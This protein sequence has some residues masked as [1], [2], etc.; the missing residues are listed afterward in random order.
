MEF[1]NAV[2][3]AAAKTMSKYLDNWPK[4]RMV[5]LYKH[6]TGANGSLGFHIVGVDGVNMV[7]ISQVQ[8]DKPA[9]LSKQIF[10]GDK[11]L[12]VNGFD[13][14]HSNHEGAAKALKKA[15]DR[16]DLILVH[17][18]AEFTEF[19]SKFQ[20]QLQ[21]VGHGNSSLQPAQS[22]R[23]IQTENSSSKS[24]HPSESASC[25]HRYVRSQID[26]DPKLDP[27]FEALGQSMDSET[28]QL[29]VRFKAG[30]VFRV[31]GQLNSDWWI[32]SLPCF[33]VYC[34]SGQIN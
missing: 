7:F 4:A 32:V 24:R 23:S 3:Y 14:S 5:T 26:Y 1:L 6:S 22:L 2:D 25:G 16:V 9:G 33:A 12:A 18:P 15:E 30:D 10:V 8:A 28:R 13:V 29:H 31:K 11:L 19:E 20:Q 17:V 27:D 21:A 34:S